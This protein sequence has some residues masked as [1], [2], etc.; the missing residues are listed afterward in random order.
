MLRGLFLLASALAA[1]QPSLPESGP[2]AAGRLEATAFP[3]APLVAVPPVVRFRVEATSGASA[4]L[5]E[6]AA[7]FEGELGPAHLRQIE[8]GDVSKALSERA[9]PAMAWADRGAVVLAPTVVLAADAELTLVAGRPPTAWPIRVASTDS[10]TLLKRAWPPADAAATA[11]LAVH[12][13]DEPLRIEGSLADPAS[14]DEELALDP[15]AVPGAIVVGAGSGGG[16]R[17]VRIGLDGDPAPSAVLP[18]PLVEGETGA[19]R[20]EPIPM[21]KV[22]ETP[23]AAPPLA[24]SSS[25]EPILSACAQI[26]DD[27]LR[28]RTPDAPLLWVFTGAAVGASTSAFDWVGSSAGGTL[29]VRGLPVDTSVE[30]DVMA[31]D[32]AGVERRVQLDVHTRPAMAHLVLNEVLANPLGAEPEQEWVELF[33][34]GSV[35]AHLAGFT[36]EDVGGSTVLPDVTLAPGGFALVV[37]EGF[38]ADDGFDAPV[39]EGTT[40]VAVAELGTNGL[41]NG[42]EPLTLRDPHGQVVSAFP[43]SPKPKA[44]RSVVRVTPGAPDGDPASFALCDG[45]PTPGA[46]NPPASP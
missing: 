32:L 31:L 11:R 14:N 3:D 13:A 44:G 7:L 24:C 15:G 29:A 23:P 25:E 9:V 39:P 5:V 37:G 6:E 19:F 17:C 18:P 27:R 1:C 35:S 33:N 45:S 34:D 16:R 8:R 2:T 22:A 28:L 21:A 10:P 42:G 26:A 30:L 46:A 38:Q 20:L 43:P 12:C 4:P 36:L 41:A 40:L